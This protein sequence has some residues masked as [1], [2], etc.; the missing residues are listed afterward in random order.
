VRNI[1]LFIRRYFN[2]VFFVII[3]IVALSMLFKYNRFH[4]A[5]FMGVAGEFTGRISEKYNKVEY[6][7][8]LKKTN[9]ALVN[10]NA[11][12]RNLLKQDFL[13]S[14]STQKIVIDSIRIDSLERFRRYLYM[15][16]KVVNNS[17]TSQ[18]NY[19]TISRGLKQ[20][21]QKDMTVVSSEG[22][23]GTVINVSNNMATVMSLLN[24]QS[25]VSSSLKKT[26]E[27]GTVEWDG[28]DPQVLTL[29]NIPKSARVN[30]GDTVVSGI[31][32]SYPPGQAVGY[33]TAVEAE[34]SSNFYSL[35]LKPATNFFNIQFVYV[36]KNLQ[37]EEQD[38][39]EK[40]THK[41]DL[42]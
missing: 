20:G 33:V 1:F 19:I 5:A 21:V 31:N 16:A 26:G 42:Q 2:F 22:I 29:R 13:P 3:Q 9:E 36:V 7:F 12:L 32:S 23:V 35:S 37:K 14:D 38:A 17:V 10:E 27:T 24:R 8:Q 28:N 11:H 34:K 39:L 40:A 4:E 30:I 41:Q 25:R 6:Y 15:P 18:T